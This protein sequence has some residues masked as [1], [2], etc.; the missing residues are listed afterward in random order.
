M[1]PEGNTHTHTHIQECVN[2]TPPHTASAALFLSE[3]EAYKTHQQRP[4]ISDALSCGGSGTAGCWWVA[5]Q[6][7]GAQGLAAQTAAAHLGSTSWTGSEQRNP[8]G[9]PLLT[10]L[11]GSCCWSSGRCRPPAGAA[12]MRRLYCPGG[13]ERRKNTNLHLASAGFK[14][15]LVS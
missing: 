7:A 1:L 9:Q 12:S 4:L 15:K 2:N 10:E 6:V 3:S 5:A 11:T 14:G 13:R 8:L